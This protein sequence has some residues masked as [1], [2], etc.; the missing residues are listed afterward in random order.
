MLHLVITVVVTVAL[1]VLGQGVATAAGALPPAVPTVTLPP[2]AAG[3]ASLTMPPRPLLSVMLGGGAS[4]DRSPG[5]MAAKQLT[6]FVSSV[7]VGRGL[8]GG[9]LGVMGSAGRNTDV[10]RLGFDLVLVLRP[11]AIALLLPPL[12]RLPLSPER[13]SGRLVRGLGLTAGPSVEL[14]ERSRNN[15]VRKGL[16]LGAHL[17][18][19]LTPAYLTH[20]LCVRVGFRRLLA[21]DVRL[22]EHTVG[23]SRFEAFAAVTVAF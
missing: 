2:D 11:L 18:V 20:E 12:A 14:L 17:D 13:W 9:E 23:S 8:V 5:E 4:R 19:P 6:T 10:S 16:A 1:G 22:G 7:G 15:A 21:G 3:N